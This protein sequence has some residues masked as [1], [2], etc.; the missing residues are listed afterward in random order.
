MLISGTVAGVVTGVLA[1]WPYAALAGWDA[2]A[3]VF[4]TWMWVVMTTM[5]S[6]PTGAH[7]TKENPGRTQSALMVLVAAVA[8]LVAV[9]FVLVSGGRPRSGEGLAG[10]AGAGAGKRGAVLIRRAHAVRPSLRPALLRR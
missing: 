4:S 8:S 1:D 6:S 10:R 9:G 3:L 5:D 2:A 7:A